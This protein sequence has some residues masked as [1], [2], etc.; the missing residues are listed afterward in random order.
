MVFSFLRNRRRKKLLAQPLP[1]AQRK[2]IERNVA[3]F[4]LLNPAE[5]AKLIA[6]ARIIAAERPFVACGGQVISDEVKLTIA[7]QASLLLLGEEGY[8]FDKVPSIL[9]YPMAYARRHSLGAKPG[10]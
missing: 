6:A 7:A 9:V 3:V 10:R 8:Y 2:V 1:E 5:Q 4:A